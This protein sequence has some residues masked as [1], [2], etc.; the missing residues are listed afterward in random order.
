MVAKTQRNR[1]AMENKWEVRKSNKS[2]NQ[3][4]KLSSKSNPKQNQ[5]NPQTNS[6]LQTKTS[7]IQPHSFSIFFF[8]FFQFFFEREQ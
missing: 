8:I 6:S 3:N 2:Q 4:Y 5:L 7:F 1:G